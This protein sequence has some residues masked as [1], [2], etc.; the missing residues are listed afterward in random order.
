MKQDQLGVYEKAMPNAFSIAQ[1]L[2]LAERAG[3]D[4]LELS[5][6][7]TDEKLSRLDMD[8]AQRRLLN[9]AQAA[10]GVRLRSMCLSGQ[11]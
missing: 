6:D 5:V 8:A 10:S 7:E 1:K 3:F 4:F 2:E 11:R 9:A